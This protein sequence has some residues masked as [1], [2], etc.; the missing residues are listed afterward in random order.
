MT[1]KNNIA[2][3]LK[4]KKVNVFLLFLVLALLFSVLTKLSED[5]TQTIAFNIETI[6]IPEDKVIVRDSSHV[7]QITLTTYGFR[8][9]K[10]Y[11]TK[12]SIKVDFQNLD[13]NATHYFWAQKREFPNVVSQFDPNIKIEGVNPDTILFRYDVNNIKKVPVVL[14]A[15]INYSPGFDMIEDYKLA[16]DSIK[17]IGPKVLTDSITQVFTKLLKL[18]DINANIMASVQLQLPEDLEEVKFSQDQVVVTAKVE[19]FTEGSI[20]VPVNIINIPDDVKIKFYPK[21]VSVLYYTSLT[22]FKTISS[23]SFII[24]CDYNELKAQDTYLIPKITQYPERVK[25]V[26]L[27]ENRIEFI[28]LQ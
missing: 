13:K 6:N 5:Y 25:N 9:M 12:P 21:T 28:L 19:K 1:S 24:E 10:Y 15:D 7:I 20:V 23:S 8:L 3:Y 16:P 22:N 18:N 4:S 17:V 2:S 27:N 26:R 14:D 11:M